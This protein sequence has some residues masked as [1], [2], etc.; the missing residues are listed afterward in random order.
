MVGG[1]SVGG[2]RGPEPAA[3]R[4]GR[5]GC[6]TGSH[7]RAERFAFEAASG[8]QNR[9]FRV[10]VA[11]GVKLKPSGERRQGPQEHTAGASDLQK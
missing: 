4:R 7:G 9:T 10:G 1:A 6:P 2:A 8:L 5:G 11:M 3:R